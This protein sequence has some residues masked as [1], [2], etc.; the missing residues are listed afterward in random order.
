MCSNRVIVKKHVCLTS[1]LYRLD[2]L[3]EYNEENTIL[4][5][6]D[7]LCVCVY[8]SYIH[9]GFSV[10]AVPR[11]QFMAIEVTRNRMGLNSVHFK[12]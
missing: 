7:F 9:C 6:T 4:G 3:K 1:L 10:V 12:K 8:R 2:A 11:V 5:R